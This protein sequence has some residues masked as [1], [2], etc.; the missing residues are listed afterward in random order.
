MYTSEGE[1]KKIPVTNL[2]TF[3][4]INDYKQ[5]LMSNS[6]IRTTGNTQNTI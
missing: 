6:S 3:I 4:I 1:L 2:K 5:Y